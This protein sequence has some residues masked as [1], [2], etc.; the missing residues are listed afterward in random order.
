MFFNERSRITDLAAKNRVPAMYQLREFV[1]AGGLM[2]YGTNLADLFRRAAVYV[3]KILKGAKPA[4]LPVESERQ[5]VL[6]HV[7]R[8]V[9]W[10]SVPAGDGTWRNIGDEHD[11]FLALDAGNGLPQ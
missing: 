10:M 2:S 9:A 4:D 3:D 5:R 11:N 1:E 8:F 6:Q 7:D